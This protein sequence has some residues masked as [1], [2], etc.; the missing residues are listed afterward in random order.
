M[1]AFSL[2]KQENSLDDPKSHCMFQHSATRPLVNT[3]A[4]VAAFGE[5]AILICLTMLQQVAREQNDLDSLQ[6]FEKVGTD[7]QLWFI[8]D[9]QDGG[10][11][12][13]MLPSDY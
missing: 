4:A 1:P 11:I 8:E 10:V 7:E 3:E 5:A 6:V 12:T 2:I 9:E 13:A